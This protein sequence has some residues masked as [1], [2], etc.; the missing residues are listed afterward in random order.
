MKTYRKV[1][2]FLKRNFPHQFPVSVR[3]LDIP[4]DFDGDCQFK[5]DHFVIRISKILPEHEAV[6]ALLHEYA[7]VLAW[8]KCTNDDHCDEWGKQYSR[9][10]RHFLREFLEQQT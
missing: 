8:D 6:E 10:Y 4:D 3:R 9:I 7:H 5:D 1:I 2:S